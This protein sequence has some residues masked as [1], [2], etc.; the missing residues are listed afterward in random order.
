MSK[1]SAANPITE[2]RPRLIPL[3]EADVKRDYDK[4]IVYWTT[5]KSRAKKDSR[6]YLIAAVR[7]GAYQDMRKKLFGSRLAVNE[8][9]ERMNF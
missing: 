9:Q 3:T 8:S 7:A 2:E 6:L 1:Y 4:W 5:V